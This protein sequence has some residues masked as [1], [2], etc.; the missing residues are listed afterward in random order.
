MKLMLF[1]PGLISIFFIS[2]SDKTPDKLPILGRH[3]YIDTPT[4]TDTIYHEIKPFSFTDQDS[5]VV[6][7]DTYKGKIYVTD[8]FFTTCP[9]IC[10]LMKIQ[11]LRVYD[12]YM[13]NPEVGILSHSIDPEYDDVSV[14]KEYVERLGVEKG[15]WHFVT[16]DK[17]KIYDMAQTSYYIGVRDDGSFEHSGKFALVDKERHIRGVY[18]GTDEKSVDKLLVDMETLLK[19]YHTK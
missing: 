18:D 2:C 19:E 17:D 9:S 14:L 6:T 8:F 13:D 15:N 1:I 5:I 4:G 7:N 3:E 10:P 11:L 16:G 12:K